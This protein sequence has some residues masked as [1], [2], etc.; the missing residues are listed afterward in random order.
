MMDW[1]CRRSHTVIGN[2]R[3]VARHERK[4]S[5]RPCHA[6]GRIWLTPQEIR[7]PKTDNPPSDLAA[8]AETLTDSAEIH[9]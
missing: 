5:G 6:G 4:K 8:S 2:G 1:V 3:D 9:L 7:D